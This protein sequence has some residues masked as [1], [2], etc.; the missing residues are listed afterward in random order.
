MS[1]YPRPLTQIFLLL[2]FFEPK[3]S[4]PFLDSDN[5]IIHGDF[6]DILILDSQVERFEPSAKIDE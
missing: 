6:V 1:Q 5:S 3:D 4:V 2:V